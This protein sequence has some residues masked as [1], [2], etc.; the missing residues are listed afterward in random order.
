M[1]KST[2]LETE[3]PQEDR[4]VIHP[5]ETPVERVLC[6]INA[7]TFTETNGDKELLEEEVPGQTSSEEA[8]GVHMMRVDPA[9]LVKFVPEHLQAWSSDSEDQEDP[10]DVEKSS[11]VP[12]KGCDEDLCEKPLK[13]L[14]EDLCENLF[15]MLTEDLCENLLKMLIQMLLSFFEEK[16]R[17][18][19]VG[20][21][22]LLVCI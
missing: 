6:V 20:I 9:T 11:G 4:A 15:K 22:F 18:S 1:A 12:Q 8:T 2:D 3:D 19:E 16:S 21:L 14:I 7:D 17:L 10:E 13:M 5:H